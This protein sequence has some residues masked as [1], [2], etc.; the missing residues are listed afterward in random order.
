MTRESESL[1]VPRLVGVQRVLFDIP[2]EVEE[3][4]RLSLKNIE[5]PHRLSHRYSTPEVPVHGSYQVTSP[6]L[7]AVPICRAP[8]TP[9]ARPSDASDTVDRGLDEQAHLYRWDLDGR[10]WT[11]SE[12]PVGLAV[13]SFKRAVCYVCTS[14]AV[15]STACPC[16]LYCSLLQ[17]LQTLDLKTLQTP[18]SS[19]QTLDCTRLPGWAGFW[20]TILAEDGQGAVIASRRRPRRSALDSGLGYVV[21]ESS[22]P[23]QA[24]DT[25]LDAC[26]SVLSFSEEDS[27]YLFAGGDPTRFR[28][29]LLQVNQT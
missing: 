4:Y 20:H 23:M 27:L 26:R 22:N 11:I 13:A 21:P 10:R 5:E 29:I 3:P 19:L 16:T 15:A 9:T 8:Q 1:K 14:H 28:A 17:K 12:T 7:R 18:L 24:Q 6:L 25:A 2:T